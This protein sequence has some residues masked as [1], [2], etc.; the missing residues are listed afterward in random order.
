MVVGTHASTP[1]AVLL[2]KTELVFGSQRTEGV[3]G[4]E[5][6]MEVSQPIDHSFLVYDTI[7]ILNSKR[8][9]G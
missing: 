6:S 8:I 1:M 3:Q 9:S 7:Y 2:G 5:W 4:C